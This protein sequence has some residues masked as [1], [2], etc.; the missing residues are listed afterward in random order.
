VR[1][2][3]TKLKELGFDCK[4]IDGSF[5]GNTQAAVVAFQRERNLEPDGVCGPKTW[6]EIYAFAPYEVTITATVLNVRSGP[7]TNY[8][9]KSQ[10][11]K[12]AKVTLVYKKSKWGKIKNGAGWICLDYAK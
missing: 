7:G 8:V 9:V 4:G 11:R 1:E 5:G 12:G 3:Q 6:A 2:L 10:L